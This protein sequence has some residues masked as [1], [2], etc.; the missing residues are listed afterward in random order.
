MQTSRLL[1][2]LFVIPSSL[3][4]CALLL[5]A[6]GAHPVAQGDLPPALAARFSQG[7]TALQDGQLGVAEN[8]FRDVLAGGGDRAFVHHNLGIVLQRRG[9]HGDAVQEFEAALERDPEFG[10]A[11]LLAGVSLLALGRT[12]EAT[13]MLERATALMPREL[14]A[15]LQLAEAYERLDNVEGLV[16]EYRAIV[17]LAPGE[18]EYA[19]RLGKAYLRLSQRAHERI[20]GIDPKSARLQQALGRE[21]LAQGQP[22]LALQAYQRAVERAPS[23]PEL[24]LALAVI[25]FNL[26]RLDEASREAAATLALEPENR[27]ARQLQTRIE[28]SRSRP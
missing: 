3:R 28:A 6:L 19:Y 26:G 1:M 23:L 13:A 20:Q 11:R 8:A 15:H 9:R 22:E 25:H 4:I 27:D 7:V 18:P 17:E 5:L 12:R 21:Y 24:H 2:R 14:A 16:D 10:P